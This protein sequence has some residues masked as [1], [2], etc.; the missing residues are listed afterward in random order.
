MAVFGIRDTSDWANSERGKNYIEGIFLLFPNAPISLTALMSKL[1]DRATDDPEF[2]VFEKGLPTQ[3][4]TVNGS[5]TSGDTTIELKGTTPAKI[6]HKGY[7]LINER[8]GEVVWIVADPSGSFDSVTVARGKGSSAAAMND[9][10]GLY[11]IGSHYQEGAARPTAVSHDVTTVVNYTQIFRTAIDIT[12]TAAATKVRIGNPM[13]EEQREK[14]EMHAIERELAYMFGTG[15]EDT[16]GA[17]PER[18]TKGLLELLTSNVTDFA[19][20]VDVDTWEIFLE[21]VFENG[22]NEK[23]ALCGN[24]ALTVLNKIARVHGTIEQT[25]PARTFGMAMQTYITPYG[26][27]QLRQH[28]LLSKNPTYQDW[29]FVVDV[30]SLQDRPLIGNGKTRR[31][32]YRENIQNPGDDAQ[33][34][35]WLTESGLGLQHEEV[36]GIF[37]NASTF[38]P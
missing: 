11:I 21:D 27:L 25:P 24:R 5:Q 37:K 3:R 17:N 35:E 19:D 30:R 4:V 29:G 36:H 8:T 18:T 6:L 10:D 20:A 16:S 38:V 7:S 12:G 32:H 22:S 26:T 23:L 33:V 1:P 2:T 34:D 9:D 15:V 31:T 13:A 28:P 14:L